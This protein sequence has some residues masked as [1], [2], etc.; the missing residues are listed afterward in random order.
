ME[1]IVYING[2]LL[3]A[4]EAKISV[5]DNGFL[6]GYGVFAGMRVYNGIVFRLDSQLNRLQKSSQRLGIR[7]NTSELHTPIQETMQA[8]NLQNGLLR[9]TISIG[10][11]S[12][13]PDTRS[14]LNPTVVINHMAYTFPTPDAYENGYKALVSSLY[15]HSGSPISEMKTL[16]YVESMLARQEA[17]TANYNEAL[18]LNE[19]GNLSESS[20]GNVFLVKNKILKTP[21]ENS[22][23]I[24]GVVREVVLQ[25]APELNI[26]AVEADISLK[27]IMNA[28]E[29]FLT[30][31]AIEIMPLVSVNDRSIGPGK[32]GPITRRLMEAYRDK[33]KR[34][35]NKP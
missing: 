12:L 15:R 13:I 25:I 20:S 2:K 22:G 16:N 27:D 17:R 9:V 29:A 30:N 10:E 31:S 1:S 11:G 24:S 4:N 3:S 18:L 28:D 26:K 35:C 7:I 21:P 5:L 6:F 23:F 19:K 34:E 14:C 8:N 33:V 32:P